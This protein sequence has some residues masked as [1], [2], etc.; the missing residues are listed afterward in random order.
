MIEPSKIRV[1]ELPR[2][3]LKDKKKLP[4]K[5][6]I[7]FAIANGVV[8]YIGRSVNARARWGSHHRY[9]QLSE[10][11]EPCIA[12]LE[13]DKALLAEV[14][15]ALIKHFQ[16]PLNNALYAKSSTCFNAGRILSVRVTK[17]DMAILERFAAQ[18]GSD[19][20]HEIRL[21]IRSLESELYEPLSDDSKTSEG[22][23]SGQ[24]SSS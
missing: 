15:K 12:Y 6:V 17:R 20:A 13:C 2:V 23:S 1:D 11:K 3:S 5:P 14:E 21:L 19:H 8:Q 18:R 10:M 4:S 16:P 22:V 9:L 7:Y 24:S